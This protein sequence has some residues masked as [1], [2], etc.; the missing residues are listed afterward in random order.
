MSSLFYEQVDLS[1]EIA[2]T[3]LWKGVGKGP[4][5]GSQNAGGD[6][7]AEG[8]SLCDGNIDDGGWGCSLEDGEGW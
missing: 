4:R 5:L 8:A 1:A 6:C 2:T 7:A 3:W